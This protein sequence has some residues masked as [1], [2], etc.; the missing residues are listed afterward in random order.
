MSLGKC[1]TAV[2][3]VALVSRSELKY[4]NINSENSNLLRGLIAA[5]LYP[6][7]AKVSGQAT[8]YVKKFISKNTEVF[9]HPSS[10]VFSLGKNPPTRHLVYQEKLRTKKLNISEISFVPTLSLLM[11]ASSSINI[12]VTMY[13]TYI[14][15]SED[16]LIKL[17]VGTY[18][19]MYLTNLNAKKQFS[20]FNLFYHFFKLQEAKLLKFL[21]VELNKLVQDK[22][23]NPALSFKD[24][25]HAQK[26]MSSVINLIGIHT[27]FLD[28]LTMKYWK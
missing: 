10:V 8:R 15:S 13:G 21:K 22:L 20:N 3:T 2:D 27:N 19:V 12:E 28:D 26:I 11:L 23:K 18:R 5:S 14:L 24:N 9:L 1:Q 25:L 6:N 16:G 4:L 17:S 7:I